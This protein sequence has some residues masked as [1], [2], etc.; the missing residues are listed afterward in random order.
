MTKSAV[1]LVGYVQAHLVDRSGSPPA[2]K[3]TTPSLAL[4]R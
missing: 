4:R 2:R 3:A 1:E